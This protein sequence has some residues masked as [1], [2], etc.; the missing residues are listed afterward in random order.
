VN[1]VYPADRFVAA[2]ENLAAKIAAGPQLAIR[3]VK[4]TIFARE[5]AALAR[6]LEREVEHQLHCFHSQ[7][8]QEGIEAFLEKRP[9]SFRGH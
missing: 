3:A 2:V 4:K 1:H 5:Q 9:P 7:D 8:C 6:A